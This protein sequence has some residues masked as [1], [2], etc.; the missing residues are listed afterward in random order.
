MKKI[1]INVKV[2]M[3][4]LILLLVG[5]GPRVPHVRG[6]YDSQ[7]D[8]YSVIVGYVDM[9]EAGGIDIDDVRFARFDKKSRLILGYPDYLD[10]VNVNKMRPGYFWVNDLVEG[11]YQLASIASVGFSAGASQYGL[12][13][14][15]S[16]TGVSFPTDEKHISHV[17]IDKPGLYFMGSF[18]LVAEKDSFTFRRI[19][20]PSEAKVLKRMLKRTHGTHWKGVI[21]SRLAQLK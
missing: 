19:K 8:K 2:A 12:S 10:G 20:D 9:T 4:L 3:V 14:G 6:I 7:V 11:E 21:E 1:V 17:K 13:R 18:K 15:N 16:F 5:C